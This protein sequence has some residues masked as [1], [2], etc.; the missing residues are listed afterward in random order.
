MY[1]YHFDLAL[2]MYSEN[3]MIQIGQNEA[4]KPYYGKTLK[5]QNLLFEWFNNTDMKIK[6]LK[7]VLNSMDFREISDFLTDCDKMGSDLIGWSNNQ[8][9]L[10]SDFNYN[11]QISMVIEIR[12][13]AEKIGSPKLKAVFFG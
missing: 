10:R 3:D 8:N 7:T 11:P 13:M 1:I 6:D 2:I 12:K 4:Q 5:K 9:K